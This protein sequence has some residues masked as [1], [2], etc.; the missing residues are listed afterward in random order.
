MLGA[1][2]TEI[3]RKFLV[4]DPP[5]AD[6]LGPGVRL[7]QGYLAEDGEVQVRVRI[8]GTAATLTVKG[9][10]GLR[11]T[12]VE[13]SLEPSAAE[14]LWPLTTGRRIEKV[15]HRVL[16]GAHVAEVDIY[17]GHLDGLCT[18]EVEFDS[19]AAAERF[20]P[21][22]WFARDVTGQPGWD[23]ATIARRGRPH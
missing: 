6:V 5:P 7:R 13:V 11:R 21:P 15:R 9:G 23:N 16:L 22:P 17:E 1:V 3:E 18:A 12:E 19:E 10:R 2:T 14:E 4:N 8:A 20:E